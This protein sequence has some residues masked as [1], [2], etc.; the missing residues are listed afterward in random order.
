MNAGGT[1]ARGHVLLFLHADT[2]L[3]HEGPELALREIDRGADA[4]CF[5]VRIRSEHARVKLGAA[6]QSLRSQIWTSATGDQAIFVRSSVFRAIGGFREELP[7]CEDLDLVARIARHSGGR[8]FA[9]V[10]HHVVTSGRRWESK[11]INR[12]IALMW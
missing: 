8:R 3:D 6:L 2:S 12:T 11:G 5:L 7:I 9:C 1:I 4:G 10:P